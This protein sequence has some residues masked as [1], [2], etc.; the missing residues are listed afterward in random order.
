MDI[1][2]QKQ[3]Y[4]GFINISIKAT[5]AVVVVMLLLAIFVA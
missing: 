4:A 3:T 2:D 1:E 5:A